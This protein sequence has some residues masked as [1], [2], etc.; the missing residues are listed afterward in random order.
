[1]AEHLTNSNSK[2]INQ[3]HLT[4]GMTLKKS[5]CDSLSS[6]LDTASIDD[7]LRFVEGK[8]PAKKKAILVKL[9]MAEGN[10]YQVHQL[11]NIERSF[12]ENNHDAAKTSEDLQSE[13]DYMNAE[14]SINRITEKVAKEKKSNSDLQQQVFQ[15]NVRLNQVE[16]RLDTFERNINVLKTMIYVSH[17]E[18]EED[19]MRLIA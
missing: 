10:E 8:L 17:L 5:N 19:I 18:E 9:L 12:I 2:Y 13:M 14:I 16:E 15:C 7:L 1:M 11:M 6:Y 4:M 3:S